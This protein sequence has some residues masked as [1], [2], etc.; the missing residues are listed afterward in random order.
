VLP[1]T[2]TG[3]F[4]DTEYLSIR[5]F[6]RLPEVNKS[7]VTIKKYVDQKRLPITEKGIPKEEGLKAWKSCRHIG[8]EKAAIAGKKFGGA[9]NQK[10]K[11]S[12]NEDDFDFEDDGSEDP[13]DPKWTPRLNKARALVQEQLAIKRK[14]ENE[15]E[16]GRWVLK[17]DVRQEASELAGNIKQKLISIAPI[18]AVTA[19]GK[20]ALQIQKIVEKHIN[21]AL[22]SLQEMEH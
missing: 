2:S 21:E 15:V 19:E 22:T 13:T 12:V 14:F 11:E 8:Y 10:K 9:K 7:H 4:M 20:T 3:G 18:I 17:T 1:L 5:A 6:S 16:Q